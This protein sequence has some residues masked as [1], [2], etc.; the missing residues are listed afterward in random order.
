MIEFIL[1]I[2]VHSLLLLLPAF[3]FHR[4]GERICALVFGLGAIYDFVL[5]IY[6]TIFSLLTNFALEKEINVT[7]SEL[8][9]SYYGEVFFLAI[10]LFGFYFT[11]DKKNTRTGKYAHAQQPQYNESLFIYIVILIAIGYALNDF[12]N[13]PIDPDQIMEHAEIKHYSNYFAMLI[14]WFSSPFKISGLILSSFVSINNKYKK[15]IRILGLAYLILVFFSALFVGW[16]GPLLW[17]PILLMSAAYLEKN[18]RYAKVAIVFVMLLIPLFSFARTYIRVNAIILQSMP[19]ED[20]FLYVIKGYSSILTGNI[21]LD[22]D[23]GSLVESFAERA[24]GLRNAVF[25]YRLYDKGA[26]AGIR[27]IMSSLYF[28]IPRVIWPEKRPPGSIDE[29]NYGSAIFLVQAGRGEPY[30]SMGPITVSGHAYWEGGW[31]GLIICA[32]ISGALWKKI[33]EWSKDKSLIGFL[34]LMMFMG[35]LLIDGLYTFK[36]PL[37][38]MITMFWSN[39]LPMYLLF[40][41]V[42]KHQHRL[43]WKR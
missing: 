3:Y 33:I 5:I 12:V 25:L 14:Y 34:V 41:L 42:Q 27:P 15:K 2:L 43:D 8:L 37:Y 35:S 38:A 30:I 29:T 10:F 11:R 28:P 17:I 6:P 23:R 39:I 31:F 16:R 1:L 4:K 21:P 9:T 40:V 20:R 26:S 19:I 32:L 24:Q 36:Q 18:F 7:P 13:P 22:E